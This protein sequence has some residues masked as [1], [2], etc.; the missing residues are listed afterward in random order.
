M[1]HKI[2]DDDSSQDKTCTHKLK[3]NDEQDKHD[4]PQAVIQDQF[5]FTNHKDIFFNE[6]SPLK[7]VPRA[8]FV[9]L[10]PTVIG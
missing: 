5:N 7:Y 4:K 10:E 1:P 8:T 9:D 2:F 3:V 6:T